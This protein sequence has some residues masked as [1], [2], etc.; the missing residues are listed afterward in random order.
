MCLWQCLCQPNFKPTLSRSCASA[1]TLS[2]DARN[3]AQSRLCLGPDLGASAKSSLC[4]SFEEARL[5]NTDH[6]VHFLA[7][8]DA[9]HVNAPPADEE[10]GYMLW[11][12]VIIRQEIRCLASSSSLQI[13]CYGK[14]RK[15]LVSFCKLMKNESDQHFINSQ[16]SPTY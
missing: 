15:C 4:K 7:V 12:N 3:S 8:L 14:W 9:L 1:W 2:T 13:I 10:T 6:C 11:N 16:P 5:E